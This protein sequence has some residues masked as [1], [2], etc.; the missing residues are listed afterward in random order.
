MKRSARNWFIWGAVAFVILVSIPGVLH[1]YTDWLW[2]GEVSKRQVF[3]TILLTRWKLGLVFGILFFILMAGNA[4][5][6]R[7]LAPRT[8]WY[9][10]ERQFRLQAAEMLEHYVARY[11]LIG[12]I[13][14]SAVLAYLVGQGMSLTYNRYL[15]FSH[16]ASF[17][18]ADPIF[19]RDIGFYVFRL[20]FWRTLWQWV[21][22][23]LIAVLLV[24]AL[25]HYLDKAIRML[26]GIPAFAPHVKAHLSVILGL[27]LLV[28]AIGYRLDAFELLY[29]PRGVVFGA[30]YSDVY[31]HLPAYMILAVVAAVCSAL[32]LVN[33]HFRGLWLPVIGLALLMVASLLLNKT[34]PALVQR[35]QVAPN[36]FV[37]EAPFI[38]NGIRLTRR[39]YQLD[40][41]ETRRFGRIQPLTTA[42]LESNPETIRNIRL[43][44]YRPLVQAYRQLQD[45]RA[46]Y[47]IGEVDVDRYTIDGDYRQVML[48]T[49]EL[50]ADDIPPPITWMKRHLMYTH[51]YGLV[52]SPVNRVSEGGRPDFLL[53]DLPPRSASRDIAV[54][55]PGIYYGELTGPEEYVIVGTK[56][57][58]LDYM[59]PQGPRYTHYR[60][61][62]GIAVS[63]PLRKIAF[64]SRFK[65]VNI[66]IADSIVP[67]SRIL[68]RRNIAERLQAVAP[69]LLQ[70]PDPYIVIDKGK[71]F[72]IHDCYT[73]SSR[74]PY[75]RPSTFELGQGGI[76]RLNYIRN[77][78]KVVTDAYN[79]TIRLFVVDPTDPLIKSYKR[80]FPGLFEPLS[81][82][83]EGL[84]RHIR[85]PELLFRV[86]AN[87][88][89]SYHMT[90]P[91]V[92]YEQ[93]DLWAVAQEM[94]G[95]GAAAATAE[96]GA[97][98]E[99]YYA[100]IRLPG[101]KS[102]EFVLLLP[103]TPAN[104]RNMGGWMGARSDGKNYGKVLVFEFPKQQLVD[105]PLQ[106]EAYVDQHP[107][108]SKDLSLWRQG[109]SEVIRGNLLV[110]PVDESLL[111]VEPLFLRSE[112]GEIPELKRV[113]VAHGGKV[114]MDETLDLALAK[115]TGAEVRAA[116]P[117]E[118]RLARP[119]P[120]E[121]AAPARPIGEMERLAAQAA[122][123]Y[124]QLRNAAARADWP[125]FGR[126]LKSLGETMER[127]KAGPR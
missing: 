38:S 68:F 30:S 23:T 112:R 4:L 107:D 99:P 98:M 42:T 92:F 46:Y 116:A 86:Q 66:L 111:Y 115:L 94:A 79:G 123:E 105:G 91:R 100:L 13:V 49:R 122:Q 28:K 102:A 87:M 32:V 97:D 62:G 51:G 85:Y 48:A 27:I 10:A 77:S 16:P 65:A 89:R 8:S 78:V 121:R 9:E 60:G 57:K 24:S 101:Q 56:E 2:Y 14:G 82:M 104:K 22:L 125:E 35:F 29:S 31:A 52:L 59:G 53:K 96:G 15:L 19:N 44:D 108:I 18:A 40:K 114:E 90:N 88:L 117:A 26:G 113:I 21:Y 75:S 25:I 58:E 3:W 126:R 61:R 47:V 71:L 67:K 41:A 109:G 74:Y 72:W 124:E 34:Y 5:L 127:M 39:A 110:I 63:G 69:F 120:A 6:A 83:P 43:W 36:E 33:L 45:L 80:I 84:R 7:F 106:I 118:E 119:G 17:G 76:V 20:P 50:S 103:F 64:S 93:E 81:A 1:L 54:S 11:L 95:K 12:I 73:I 37:R 55:R 70:D